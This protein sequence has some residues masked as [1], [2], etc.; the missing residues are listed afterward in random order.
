MT[1]ISSG[2]LALQNAGTNPTTTVDNIPLSTT[3][4]PNVDSSVSIYRYM[5][6]QFGFAYTQQWAG[7]LYGYSLPNYLENGIYGSGSI[8]NSILGEVGGL[9]AGSCWFSGAP[10]V[11]FGAISGSNTF[12]DDSGTTRTITAALWGLPSNSPSPNN[13]SRWFI[14]AIDGTAIPNLDLTFNKVVFGSSTGSA[15][16][17]FARSDAAVYNGNDNGNSVWAWEYDTTYSSVIDGGLGTN[18]NTKTFKV[19]L[20]EDTISLNNGIAEEFG[21]DDSSNVV[22]SQYYAGGIYTPASTTGVPTTGQIKFSDFL[23][24]SKLIT[25]AWSATGAND[26]AG[27]AGL[28]RIGRVITSYYVGT[29]QG[30]GGTPSPLPTDG[31][32]ISLTTQ[33]AAWYEGQT[34]GTTGFRWEATGSSNDANTTWWNK[35]IISRSGQTDVVLLRSAATTNAMA[36]FRYSIFW[37]EPTANYIALGEFTWTFSS[38]A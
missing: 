22:L 36:N 33:T 25:N 7:A 32:G 8:F 2:Q 15:G 28:Q 35:V 31:F 14:L 4:T 12:V 10:G 23:G 16:A 30:S 9:S 17:T 34:T 26:Y 6:S 24:T 38:E 3:I 5:E 18:T 21:G 19:H 13:N 11:A 27:K 29:A 1:I 37:P 20:A